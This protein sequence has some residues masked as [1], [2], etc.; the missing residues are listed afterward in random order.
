MP[1]MNIAEHFDLPE[2]HDHRAGRDRGPSPCPPQRARSDEAA[3]TRRTL[4]PQ[5]PSGWEQVGDVI[6][7]QENNDSLG[8]RPRNLRASVR[9]HAV[10][11]SPHRAT[12]PTKVGCPQGL[13]E[14]PTA[15]HKV[16]PFGLA[17]SNSHLWRAQFVPIT[18]RNC[19][20]SRLVMVSLFLCR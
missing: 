9:A 6:A 20:H 18:P 12:G 8:S 17:K 5:T 4:D 7:R 16:S 19:G 2:L 14:V 10:G 1:S 15:P 13:A 11:H 3:Y